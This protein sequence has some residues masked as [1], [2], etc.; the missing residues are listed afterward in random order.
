MKHIF[1]FNFI[2]ALFFLPIFADMQEQIDQQWATNYVILDALEAM[3]LQPRLKLY[4]KIDAID[5]QQ[6]EEHSQR[7]EQAIDFNEKLQ[8]QLI[9]AS[10][11]QMQVQD[12]VLQHCQMRIACILNT[13]LMLCRKHQFPFA[14]AEIERG[15]ALISNYKQTLDAMPLP[16]FRTPEQFMTQ[17]LYLQGKI[18]RMCAGLD[19][20]QLNLDALK[21]SEKSYLA[22]LQLTPD[23]PSI[24][25]SLG[26]LYLDMG[27]LE[28]AQKQL[29]LVCLWHPH[30]PEFLHGLAYFY[31][32]QEKQNLVQGA[33]LNQENLEKARDLFERAL[34]LFTEF[35]TLNSRIFL[36]YGQLLVLMQHPNEALSTFNAGLQLEPN[37]QLLLFERG[38]LLASLGNHQ[39][40]LK[41]LRGG[42][43]ASVANALLNNKYAQ[44]INTLEL[45]K[46]KSYNPIH[47]HKRQAFEKIFTAFDQYA[48]KQPKKVSCFI[49][50]AWGI[51]SH[52]KWV[53]QF[54]EDLEKAGFHVLLDRWFTRKGYD[55][56]NFV[57]K[58]LAED[59]DYIIVI[60]SKRF[61]EKYNFQS[62]EKN[63]REHVVKVEAR[64][65]NYLVSF[66]T[67]HSD[68][69]IPL[70]AEG[71]PIDSLPPFFRTK[72]VADFVIH[73][74]FDCIYELMRDLHRIPQ[75][76]Q[77]FK[78]LKENYDAAISGA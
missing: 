46:D 47:D 18:H 35:N 3:Q 20:D 1:I 24:H 69:V 43:I 66:N 53:E 71:T 64:L 19:L 29:E 42:R 4:A 15:L 21:A 62:E 22:A 61:L 31:Y 57:E 45:P 50:Y 75:R 48:K 16:G 63:Q 55:T 51:E 37:H 60:G 73:D 2:C 56:M 13:S 70:V 41:D 9:D 67:L 65:L 40:A 34:Q 76:D 39:A 49:S 7:I 25:C 10:P 36:D 52:E 32:K 38:I 74:Y 5:I 59:T 58:I 78:Q 33:A 44:A 23:H 11:T 68:R 77:L 8:R 6:C 17:A 26:F 72:N 28:D 30:C 14:M 27:R 54:A 12:L